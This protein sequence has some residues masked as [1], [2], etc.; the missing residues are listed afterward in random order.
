[1]GKVEAGFVISNSIV[2]HT[3]RE[4]ELPVVCRDGQKTANSPKQNSNVDL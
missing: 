3:V 1:M 4:P 2:H